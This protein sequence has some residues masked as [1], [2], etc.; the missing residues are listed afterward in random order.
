[1]LN[2]KIKN[3][4]IKIDS[5]EVSDACEIIAHGWRVSLYRSFKDPADD[6]ITVIRDNIRFTFKPDNSKS[7]CVKKYIDGELVDS[8]SF[9]DPGCGLVGCICIREI[10]GATPYAFFRNNKLL[11]LMDE[12]GVKRIEFPK[13]SDTRFERSVFEVCEKDAPVDPKTTPPPFHT[14]GDYEI[15]GI[16]KFQDRYARKYNISDASYVYEY[17]TGI[18][19]IP[20]IYNM[21]HLYSILAGL[22]S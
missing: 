19:V 10:P 20:W 2:E 1:M 6:F 18:F 11:K 15:E 21:E 17:N 8:K 4:K 7:I 14:D 5:R 16:V 13:T 12:F 3:T 22:M 9:F